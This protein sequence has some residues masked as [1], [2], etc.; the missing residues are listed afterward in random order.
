MLIKWEE[1]SPFFHEGVPTGVLHIGSHLA[2]ELPVY[3]SQSLNR[4]IWIEANPELIG[5]L[6][7]KIGNR[8]GHILYSFTAY[9]SDHESMP[10][11][12]LDNVCSSSV[13]EPET[14]LSEYPYIRPLKTI[15]TQTLTIDT[16]LSTTGI[17][18]K[19][20]NYV[21]LNVQG[22]ELSVLKGMK[23]FLH[24]VSYVYTK[25]NEKHLFKNC[26]FV[27][28]IDS[29]LNSYGFIRI[30]TRMTQHGWGD[31]FYMKR[32]SRTDMLL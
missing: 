9:G 4:V 13:L 30:K 1:I 27:S 21:K 25:V 8:P 23:S 6:R 19:G 15:T 3:E 14:H 7:S 26:A 22:A 32:N 16:F 29:F 2:E 31:A 28:D 18:V 12:I 10:F 5:P 17:N 24:N 20:L 11:H